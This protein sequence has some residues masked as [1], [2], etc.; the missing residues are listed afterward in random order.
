MTPFKVLG[1]SWIPCQW[2]KNFLLSL[3]GG[4]VRGIHHDE[5]FFNN[6]VLSFKAKQLQDSC[7]KTTSAGGCASGARIEKNS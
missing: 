3:F 5:V 1:G 6:R 2:E 7:W 4:R